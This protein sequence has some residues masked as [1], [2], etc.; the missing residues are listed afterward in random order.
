MNE[1]SADCGVPPEREALDRFGRS[2]SAFERPRM[3]HLRGL[4][5]IAV[6]QILGSDG[7]DAVTTAR[8]A[9]NGKQLHQSECS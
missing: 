2:L 5:G 7:D 1:L 3:V 4:P 9:W 8:F 6:R